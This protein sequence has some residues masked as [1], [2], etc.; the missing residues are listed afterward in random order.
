M[1][2]S[3]SFVGPKNYRIEKGFIKALAR[4]LNHSPSHT[5]SSVIIFDSFPETPIRMGS[6]PDIGRFSEAVDNLRYLGSPS[7]QLDFALTF[8][9]RGFST[10]R[11]EV[12][13]IIIVLTNKDPPNS[14]SIDSLAG[15][16]RREGKVVNVIG[17]GDEA[18][19]PNLR[20]LAVR[21][22]DMFT[23]K[24]F[25]DMMDYVPL[26][27]SNILASELIKMYFCVHSCF[28][29]YSRVNERCSI[30]VVKA[31]MPAGKASLGE[32]VNNKLQ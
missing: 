1:V 17:V 18:D 3:S 9:A 11:P 31:K 5:Q 28:Y 25:D 7:S 4:V 13:K 30:S 22:E 14:G 2:D 32:Y 6:Y 26:V 12:P 24:T 23:P 27:A 19:F 8:A 16:L 20:R 15:I 21:P 29:M 10:N